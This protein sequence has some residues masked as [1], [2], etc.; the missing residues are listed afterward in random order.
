MRLKGLT[1]ALHP[2]F[3]VDPYSMSQLHMYL[4]SLQLHVKC[5]YSINLVNR[6]WDSAKIVFIFKQ[7]VTPKASERT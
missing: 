3:Y 4:H 6:T 7:G 1:E 5:F 2:S